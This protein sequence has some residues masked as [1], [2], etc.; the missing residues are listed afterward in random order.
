MSSRRF[1]NEFRF[2]SFLLNFCHE[3][4]SGSE[5]FFYFFY[6]LFFQGHFL[7]IFEKY[8]QNLSQKIKKKIILIFQDNI[9]QT[10]LKTPQKIHQKLLLGNTS[11]QAIYSDFCLKTLHDNIS[12]PSGCSQKIL[13]LIWPR[14]SSSVLQIFPQVIYKIVSQIKKFRLFNNI[15]FSTC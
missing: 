12:K 6:F 7:K 1:V 14:V 3:I 15:C 5:Y 4:L 13:T 11:P 10:F 2:I 8:C 9:Y